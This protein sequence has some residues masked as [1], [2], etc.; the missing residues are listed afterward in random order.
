MFRETVTLSEKEGETVA[1]VLSAVGVKLVDWMGEIDVEYVNRDLDTVPTFVTV[2]S[3]L[4]LG[5]VA[6]EA[7]GSEWV[8]E[9]ECVGSLETECDTDVEREMV[10]L[11]VGVKDCDTWFET[12][13]D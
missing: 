6:V 9:L 10:S 7:V 12:E 1:W 5:I 11:G 3:E 13:T 2:P 8:T 4:R